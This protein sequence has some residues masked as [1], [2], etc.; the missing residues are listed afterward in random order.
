MQFHKLRNRQ[1]RK[2]I[3]QFNSRN[4]NLHESGRGLA[5]DPQAYKIL[6]PFSKILVL[7]NSADLKSSNGNNGKNGCSTQRLAAKLKDTVV[8]D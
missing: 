7:L 6:Y 3:S 8:I 2:L 5:E 1:L 4:L